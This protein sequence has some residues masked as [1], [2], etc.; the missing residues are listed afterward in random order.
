MTLSVMP[1]CVTA[2]QS[3]DPPVSVALREVSAVL[4]G[5]AGIRLPDGNGEV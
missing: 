5:M 1:L 3:H 2:P 4:S